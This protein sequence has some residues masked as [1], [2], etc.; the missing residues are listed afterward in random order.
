MIFLSRENYFI[1]LSRIAHSVVHGAEPVYYFFVRRV[2]C[3]ISCFGSDLYSSCKQNHPRVT[4]A[5]LLF[6]L[7]FTGRKHNCSTV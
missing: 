7:C 4:L 6:T 1:F 2:F 5:C 3:G